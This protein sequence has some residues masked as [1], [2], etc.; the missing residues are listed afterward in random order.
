MRTIHRALAGMAF[1]LLAATACADSMEDG[2]VIPAAEIPSNLLKRVQCHF[3][4]QVHPDV[5]R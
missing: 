5:A 4:R 1:V 2:G 3:T